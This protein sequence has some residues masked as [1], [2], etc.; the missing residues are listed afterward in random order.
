M[1]PKFAVREDSV[2]K[3][4]S[5]LETSEQSLNANAQSFITAIADLP[6]V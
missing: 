3:H 6:S 4:A 2:V 5:N 1:G